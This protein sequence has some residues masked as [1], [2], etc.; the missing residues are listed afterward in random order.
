MSSRASMAPVS[1]RTSEPMLAPQA[2]PHGS[3]HVLRA[4]C[5]SG[6]HRPK[7][8]RCGLMKPVLFFRAG[9]RS[10]AIRQPFLCGQVQNGGERCFAAA[11]RALQIRF[12]LSRNS[13]AIDFRLHA[14]HCSARTRDVGTGNIARMA[15]RQQKRRREKRIPGVLKIETDRYYRAAACAMPACSFSASALSVASHENVSSVRPKCP[16][17]AVLR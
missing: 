11:R 5:V 7:A 15:P 16:N 1:I 14:L 3:S 12:K 17:A 2:L 8:F 10:I 6:C 4:M 13:P 9:I